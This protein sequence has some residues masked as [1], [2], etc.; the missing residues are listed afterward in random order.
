LTKKAKTSSSIFASSS[1]SSETKKLLWLTTGCLSGKV[2]AMRLSSIYSVSSHNEL[3][4]IPK[5]TEP[6]DIADEAKTY[7]PV[8][9]Q[10]HV[11]GRFQGYFE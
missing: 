3:H 7:K 8:Q 5:G 1:N 2:E 11:A 4:N 6:S 9:K 10:S